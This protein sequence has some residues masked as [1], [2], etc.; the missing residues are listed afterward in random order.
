MTKNYSEDRRSFLRSLALFGGTAVAASLAGE[1]RAAGKKP[2]LL[3]EKTVQS[4]GYR[5]TEHILKYYKS[6]AI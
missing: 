6:A 1:S 3:P 5:E 2:L 4:L